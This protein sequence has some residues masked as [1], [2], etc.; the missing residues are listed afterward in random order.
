MKT[1]IMITGTN[2]SGKTTLA[3]SLI[4]RFGGIKSANRTKTICN[5]GNVALVGKYSY[6][7]NYGGVDSLNC[8]N[9]LASIIQECFLQNDTVIFE[10]SYL[11]SF[12]INLTNALFKAPRQLIVFLY[13]PVKILD[14]R[15]GSRSG[16]KINKEIIDK[17]N[18][19]LRSANKFASIGVPV[20]C[21][22]T[23]VTSSEEIENK[24][25]KWL[26]EY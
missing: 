12:G 3:K 20:W 24:I 13:A 26:D 14:E 8:T 10:G 7:S 22:D 4:E 15:L 2:A 25:A 23:S 18:C 11:N 1:C 6:D 5:N 17:Q 9:S 16:K 19:A 21:F